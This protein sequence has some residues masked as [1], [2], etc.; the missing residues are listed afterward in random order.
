M[1]SRRNDDAALGALPSAPSAPDNNLS[2]VEQLTDELNIQQAV[3][4][5]LVDFPGSTAEQI[6]AARGRI[7]D[8]K[9]QLHK[10]KGKGPYPNPPA[11]PLPTR[12]CSHTTAVARCLLLAAPC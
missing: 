4:V 1:A 3:L 11:S 10:A 12:P 2:L 9:R 8:I 5:S 6:A 7:A